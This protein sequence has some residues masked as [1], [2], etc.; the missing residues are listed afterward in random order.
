M[1]YNYKY[2]FLK[3][4]IYWNISTP[5]ALTGPPCNQSIIGHG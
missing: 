4:I 2:D 5:Q 1:C 3:S